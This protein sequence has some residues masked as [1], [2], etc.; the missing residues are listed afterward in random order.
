MGELQVYADKAGYQTWLEI[1]P[2]S[3]IFP[4]RSRV[5]AVGLIKP[6]AEHPEFV[7]GFNGGLNSPDFYDAVDEC[8]D[9]LAA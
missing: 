8:I 1:K 6:R 5:T 4:P 7:C 3:D 9:W 2:I